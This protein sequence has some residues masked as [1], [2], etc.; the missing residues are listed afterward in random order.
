MTIFLDIVTV[1]SVVGDSEGDAVD[2][3]FVD[4]EDF[5]DVFV[6]NSFVLE[7]FCT[8]VGRIH[9]LIVLIGIETVIA[10]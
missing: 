1:K 7:I 8:L 3:G 9:K 10:A 5:I 6:C 4:K 2:S